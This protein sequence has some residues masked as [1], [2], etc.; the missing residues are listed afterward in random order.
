MHSDSFIEQRSPIRDDS[1]DPPSWFPKRSVVQEYMVD[2]LG[3]L[4]PGILLVTGALLALGTP[5]FDL[6]STLDPESG[7]RSLERFERVLGAIAGAPATILFFVCL[8]SAL[9]VYVVGHV[10]YRRDPKEPDRASFRL[11][12]RDKL[13]DH[14]VKKKFT[15]LGARFRIWKEGAEQLVS[16]ES[17]SEELK[18]DFG[19]TSLE[20]CEFPYPHFKSYL[21]HRGLSY[22]DEL[23][24]WDK[25]SRSK[26]HINILKSRLTQRY[27]AQSRQ[28]V[29]IEAHVRLASGTWYVGRALNALSLLGLTTLAM[30]LLPSVA[31]HATDPVQIGRI[32]GEHFWMIVP[33]VSV[34]LVSRFLHRKVERFFHYQRMREVG[35]VLETAWF[36]FRECP[37]LLSPPF[38]VSKLQSTSR[39]SNRPSEDVVVDG[40]QSSVTIVPASNAE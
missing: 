34:L 30:A 39:S 12:L 17:L 26:F 25:S 6:Q 18:R 11:L 15:R 8:S 28:L 5:L 23:V 32:L 22:L 14:L 38:K 13:V 35:F 31:I 37:D 33:P 1:G 16:T 36:A 10:F 7:R 3:G 21:G 9:M 19:A 24:C 29:H 27:P 20:E 4:V 40:N 2:I